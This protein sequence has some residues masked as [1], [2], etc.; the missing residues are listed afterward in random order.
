MSCSIPFA[1]VVVFRWLRRYP[2]DA[3]SES[4]S[5][6]TTVRLRSGGLRAVDL[7]EQDYCLLSFLIVGEKA[8]RLNIQMQ[9]I[10]DDLL[11]MDIRNARISKH[12]FNRRYALAAFIFRDMVVSP[13]V[14]KPLCHFSLRQ[15]KCL[16]NL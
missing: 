7:R 12:N 11:Y 2:A 10:V 3:T 4:K 13:V 6:Q 9:I 1:E 8:H 16:T 5:D 15:T 14:S